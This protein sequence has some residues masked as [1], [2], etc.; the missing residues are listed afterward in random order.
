MSRLEFV[1]EATWILLSENILH[2]V[3]R[4]MDNP[5][6]EL[7]N[8]EMKNRCLQKLENLLKDSGHNF[9]N[10]LTIP[11]PTHNIEQLDVTNR[12]IFEELHY[13]KCSLSEEHEECLNKLTKEQRSV[14]DRIITT[15]KRNKGGFFFLYGHGGTEKTF[16]WRTL[17]SAIRSKG[18][19]VLTVASTGIALLLLPGGRT[20]HSG[21]AIP[22]NPTKDST[23][24]IK[25]DSPLASLIVKTKLII[26]D[27]AP[28]MHRYCFEAL[29]KTLRDILRFENVSNLDQPFGGQIVVLGGD[30]RQIL[31][32]ITKGNRQN[33]INATINSSYFLANCH[34][35]KQTNNMRL[36]GNHAESDLN[37]RKEFAD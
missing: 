29:D 31:P 33:I 14:Y 19:I 37:D 18:D 1:R 15:V 9:H 8:D 24:N 4:V 27:E 20:T 3:Q 23:C 17:S 12:L 28:M 22:L 25:Q 5:G 26:W 2:E 7:S 36:E 34:L 13:N 6:I 11:K 32:V 16:I 21:F 35:L 30:F 10:F